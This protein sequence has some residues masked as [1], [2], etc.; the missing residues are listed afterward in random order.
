[1]KHEA[2]EPTIDLELAQDL[3][4]SEAFTAAKRPERCDVDDCSDGS[5]TGRRTV[6]EPQFTEL[7]SG[8]PE[9]FRFIWQADD[10]RGFG[11]EGRAMDAIFGGIEVA[12]QRRISKEVVDEFQFGGG[13]Y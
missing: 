2:H 3:T 6:S 5:Q 1:M 10:S 4:H 7:W 13:L 12:A 11:S 9:G 8:L